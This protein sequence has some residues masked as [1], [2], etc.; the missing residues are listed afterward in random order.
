MY[1]GRSTISPTA[2]FNDDRF[3]A[4]ST[5][6]MCYPEAAVE[7]KNWRILSE[8]SFTARTATVVSVQDPRVRGSLGQAPIPSTQLQ[9]HGNTAIRERLSGRDGRCDLPHGHYAS[10]DFQ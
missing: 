3:T 5:A 8:Q 2:A 1:E 9:T 7:N 10:T 6:N 4:H